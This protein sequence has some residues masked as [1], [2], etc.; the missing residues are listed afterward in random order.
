MFLLYFLET[1]LRTSASVDNDDE[2]FVYVP[3][4]PRKTDEKV[5]KLLS[6][7]KSPLNIGNLFN[8]FIAF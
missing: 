7:L 5:L 4:K 3:L 1:L 2:D 8:T 6:K